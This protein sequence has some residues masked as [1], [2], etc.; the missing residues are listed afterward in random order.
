MINKLRIINNNG[1]RS[2]YSKEIKQNKI[3]LSKMVQFLKVLKFYIKIKIRHNKNKKQGE[4]IRVA[5]NKQRTT[6]R[7]IK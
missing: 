5:R 2:D 6:L 7:T 1:L 3:H 4:K